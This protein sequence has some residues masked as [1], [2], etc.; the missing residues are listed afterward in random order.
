MI[1]INTVIEMM[2]N[3][4]EVCKMQHRS[5]KLSCNLFGGSLS[6]LIS[7]SVSLTVLLWITNL[8]LG[9]NGPIKLVMGHHSIY[10][11]TDEIS[12]LIDW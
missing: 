8:M 6:F 4:H 12:I 3:H 11:Y 10:S 2:L 7:D 5:L 9:P 1:E